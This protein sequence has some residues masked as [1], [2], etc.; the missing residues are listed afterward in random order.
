MQSSKS[1]N[2]WN[3]HHHALR[4]MKPLDK[5]LD[6]TARMLIV[7]DP[8]VPDYL[9]LVRGEDRAAEVLV[10]EPS[11]NGIEQISDRL[12]ERSVNLEKLQMIVHGN[13][14]R[15][16][17]GSV[18]LDQETLNR[19]ANTLQGWRQALMPDAK[20][21]LYGNT[22]VMGTEGMAFMGRLSQLTGALVETWDTLQNSDSAN[23]LNL[24]LN[25]D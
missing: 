6:K 24:D 12:T 11:G 22:I 4:L 18:W 14:G 25:G 8:T 17:L 20:I 5:T 13:P 21:L 9:A 23:G 10:L 1:L 7:V 19:Y 16:Q 2:G 3:E 15:V